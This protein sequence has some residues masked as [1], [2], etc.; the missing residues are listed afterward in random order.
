MDEKRWDVVSDC[1][2]VIAEDL[3][4]EEAQEWLQKGLT[5]D[6]HFTYVIKEHKGVK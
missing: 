2:T 1:G 3:T 5:D 4:R 6:L